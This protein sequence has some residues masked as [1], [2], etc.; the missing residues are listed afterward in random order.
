MK[1][2]KRCWWAREYYCK[3]NDD[4]KAGCYRGKHHTEHALSPQA[5]GVGL[6]LGSEGVGVPHGVKLSYLSRQVNGEADVIRKLQSHSEP[7]HHLGLSNCRHCTCMHEVGK[8]LVK[9]ILFHQHR[10]HTKILLAAQLY[11]GE[12]AR[13]RRASAGRWGRAAA[14]AEGGVALWHG[15]SDAA[16]NG[17]RRRSP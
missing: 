16:G 17:S 15:H 9:A 2:L 8:K 6:D 10:N 14:A 1:E 12:L 7:D 3:G 11:D 5:G 13:R 4:K